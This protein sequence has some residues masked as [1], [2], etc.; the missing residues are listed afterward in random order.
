MVNCKTFML[1]IFDD[2]VIPYYLTVLPEI[3]E[4]PDISNK[5]GNY[6]VNGLIS[7]KC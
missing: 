5:M 6:F 4:L 3:I 1:G 2:G 7:A